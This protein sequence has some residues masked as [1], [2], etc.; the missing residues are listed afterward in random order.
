MG[1]TC[2]VHGTA[3]CY[4]ITAGGP[5]Q[6]LARTSQS[7]RVWPAPPDFACFCLPLK[8]ACAEIGIVAQNSNKYPGRLIRPNRVL[9]ALLLCLAAGCGPWPVPADL[10]NVPQNVRSLGAAA[11]WKLP[12]EDQD[13]LSRQYLAHQYRPWLAAK[14]KYNADDARQSYAKIAEKPGWGANS[15]R[16]DR[17]WLASLESLANLDA[18][19]GRA[20]PA[21]T[22]GRVDLRLLP[23]NR[24]DYPGDRP[25][26]GFPFDRLQQSALPPGNPLLVSQAS[27]DG[28]WLWVESGVAAGWLPAELVAFL[29]PGKTAEV[30]SLPLLAVTAEDA[31][32]Y[33]ESGRFLSKASIG[34]VFPLLGR[35]E[36]HWRVLFPVRGQDG[37]ANFVPAL[38]TAGKGSRWPLPLES[39]RVATL[40]Q[41]MLGRPYGWGGL[42]GWRDCSSSV[43]ELFA[44]FGLWLDRN[45]GDQAKNGARFFDLAGL[46]PAEKAALIRERAIPLASLLWMPGHIMLYVGQ[47]EDGPL[48]WHS[49]WGAKT[50]EPFRGEGRAVVGQTAVTTLNPG[51]E[52]VGFSGGPHGLLDRVQGLVIL[53]DPARLQRER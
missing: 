4:R 49:M 21:V 16:H 38:L 12:V 9:L 37:L 48:V 3:G 43:K 45:S 23:T 53:L 27:S 5:K 6:L 52:I 19:Q 30:M 39:R 32:F 1:I 42:Y 13:R 40:A 50:W 44:P 26:E 17:A 7:P 41:A 29:P 47:G 35:G 46:D 36:N 14:P 20:R 34:A 28:S 22:L 31:P 15:R 51:R 8:P 10:A 2:A 11:A 18:F 25:K 33:A 24:P